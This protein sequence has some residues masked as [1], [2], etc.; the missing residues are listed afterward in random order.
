[1]NDLKQK[2]DQRFAHPSTAVHEMKRKETQPVRVAVAAYR[3]RSLS[4]D[5]AGQALNQS[6]IDIGNGVERQTECVHECQTR[7]RRRGAL[8]RGG[9]RIGFQIQ[10][11]RRAFGLRQADLQFLARLTGQAIRNP[12]K[13]VFNGVIPSAANQPLHDL[14]QRHEKSARTALAISKLDL[15]FDL[16]EGSLKYLSEF[17]SLRL[18]I[19][20]RGTPD[21]QMLQDCHP[22]PARSNMTIFEIPHRRDD[23]S[24]SGGPD[25]ELFRSRCSFKPP[26]VQK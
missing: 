6:G 11:P 2:V 12:C 7:G 17:A 10:K 20:V 4:I 19:S 14:V 3:R 18:A 26:S 5:A 24:G 9:T 1:M 25:A 21:T 22:M 23:R 13:Q 15:I 16:P 8:Q